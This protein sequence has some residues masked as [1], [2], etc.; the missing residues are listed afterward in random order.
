MLVVLI[1][2]TAVHF[3]HTDCCADAAC[4]SVQVFRCNLRAQPGFDCL[5]EVATLANNYY[6]ASYILGDERQWKKSRKR[7]EFK[8]VEWSSYFL[9]SNLTD[10][11]LTQC[12]SFLGLP[13]FCSTKLYQ[14]LAYTRGCL[15]A[16]TA[17][18]LPMQRAHTHETSGSQP[19]CFLANCIA[20]KMKWP[21]IFSST[22]AAQHIIATDLIDS[23]AS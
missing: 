7:S 9:G 4:T 1:I 8:A 15:T 2:Q 19:K 21:C 20:S 14:L 13:N 16:T 23:H 22:N 17:I 12:R 18:H 10:L 5:H 11:L 6:V 3:D